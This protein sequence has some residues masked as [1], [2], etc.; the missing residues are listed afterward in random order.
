MPDSL[1]NPALSDK[2]RAKSKFNICVMPPEELDKRI[3]SRGRQ[4]QD[5]ISSVLVDSP[6]VV[7]LAGRN[8]R[9]GE[10]RGSQQS[11]D[12]HAIQ[13]VQAKPP[14]ANGRAQPAAPV[15]GEIAEDSVLANRKYALLPPTIC[16]RPYRWGAQAV[17]EADLC[18]PDEL[19]SATIDGDVNRQKRIGVS[20]AQ[21]IRAI[22]AAA[23]AQ[24]N[25]SAAREPPESNEIEIS[26]RVRPKLT[27]RKRLG[28]VNLSCKLA[29]VPHPKPKPK[30]QHKPVFR[31]A[32]AYPHSDSDLPDPPPPEQVD[33]GFVD[34]AWLELWA[35]P[36][37]AAVYNPSH[38][39]LV[40]PDC[41]RRL[42][43]GPGLLLGELAD[44]AG[45][46]PSHETW[47]HGSKTP[48][49]TCDWG[50]AN[51]RLTLDRF[52]CHAAA[53]RLAQDRLAEYEPANKI[54][55]RSFLHITPK[56][57]KYVEEHAK[58]AYS[59][60]VPELLLTQNLTQAALLSYLLNFFA[61]HVNNCGQDRA[62]KGGVF[63]R[64]VHWR[65]NSHAEIA[66]RTGLSHQ[67]IEVGGRALSQP[68]CMLLDRDRYPWAE[69][70][71]QV[72]RLA[73]WRPVTS[74]LHFAWRQ[75]QEAA[76]A[77]SDPPTVN[78]DGANDDD[79]DAAD[80]DADDYDD[81]ERMAN[82]DA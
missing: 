77:A 71:K 34:P 6:A 28:N 27:P 45:I 39:T 22:T 12:E 57:L 13:V 49:Y 50:R 72:N 59:I 56:G 33:L 25:D 58:T 16:R 73:I 68:W 10:T 11:A 47:L 4:S 70:G 65:V 24:I 9:A 8:E 1:A 31:W 55:R 80:D 69:K 20:R 37:M 52:Q 14:S 60:G 2:S 29:I 78:D 54:C 15:V 7:R 53:R 26:D 82:D 64:D 18:T 32:D 51:Q 79:Y 66:E 30:L 76:L 44:Y 62:R 5:S 35:Q 23:L 19:E 3:H 75:K 63:W 21:S 81:D 74:M 38:Y 67:Q 48:A 17:V 43:V 40:F 42:G 46:L 41:V 36:H 61:P